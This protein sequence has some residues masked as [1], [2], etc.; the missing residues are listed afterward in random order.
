MDESPNVMDVDDVTGNDEIVVVELVNLLSIH[1]CL[2]APSC[3]IRSTR[4]SGPAAEAPDNQRKSKKRSDIR[5][6]RDENL[7]FSFRFF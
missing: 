3:L 6:M 5:I 2:T 7:F 4:L 1:G